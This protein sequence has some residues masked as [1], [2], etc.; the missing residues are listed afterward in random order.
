MHLMRRRSCSH[1]VRMLRYK[2][3][4]QRIPNKIDMALVY[5][6]TYN[7]YAACLL[8]LYLVFI[9]CVNNSYDNDTYVK[10]IL[11]VKY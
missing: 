5:V 6:S 2:F 10:L 4:L 9:C 1:D 7:I 11:V 8:N 3:S